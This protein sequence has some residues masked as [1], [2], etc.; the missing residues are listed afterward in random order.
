MLSYS[1]HY[2][3][4]YSLLF[5]SCICCANFA[6]HCDL[7]LQYS[8]TY[9][10]QR[11]QLRQLQTFLVLDSREGNRLK[12]PVRFFTTLL[13]PLSIATFPFETCESTNLSTQ[14]G[15]TLKFSFEYGR[16]AHASG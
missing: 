5:F 7:V 11:R 9:R 10:R 8:L 1:L 3:H 16:G 14:V 13:L 2:C 12:L 4:R 15:H 6:R